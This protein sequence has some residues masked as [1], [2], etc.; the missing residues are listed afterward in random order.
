MSLQLGLDSSIFNYP[1]KFNHHWLEK[2]DFLGFIRHFWSRFSAPMGFSVMDGYIACGSKINSVFDYYKS[3]P[4]PMGSHRFGFASHIS[5]QE[6]EDD[7]GQFVSSGC[8]RGTLFKE[9]LHQ[10]C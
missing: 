2:P 9:I 5:G 3:L 1:L 6:M 4:M 8:W 10:L 7:S